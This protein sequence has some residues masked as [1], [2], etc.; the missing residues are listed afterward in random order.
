MITDP[1]D[2]EIIVRIANTTNLNIEDIREFLYYLAC[3][4]AASKSKAS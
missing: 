4:E 3:K 2:K 1:T